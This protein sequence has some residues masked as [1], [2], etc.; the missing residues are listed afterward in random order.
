MFIPIYEYAVLGLSMVLAM[1]SAL[2][3][4]EYRRGVGF[5]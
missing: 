3:E 2:E 4:S 1:A 5:I